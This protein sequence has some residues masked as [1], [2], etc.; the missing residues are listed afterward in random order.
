MAQALSFGWNIP[1]YTVSSMSGFA[2][3]A[4]DFAIAVDARSGGV[5]IQENF[6]RPKLIPRDQAEKTLESYGLIASPHPEK[7]SPRPGLI[8]TLPSPLLLSKYAEFSHTPNL[9]YLS[10]LE[11]KSRIS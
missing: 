10:S 1:L 2:P 8:R 11:E 5:Y 4:P 6:T 7:F 3:N 9:E